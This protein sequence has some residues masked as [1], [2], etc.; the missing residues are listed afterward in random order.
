VGDLD[1]AFL[2]RV[3]DPFIEGR[4]LREFR[5]THEQASLAP[6]GNG[7]ADLAQS[8]APKANLRRLKIVET[9]HGF[10]SPLKDSFFP[11]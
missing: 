8:A 4:E 10:A 7:G 9:F 2:E 3:F 1:T 6:A 5:D 11:S